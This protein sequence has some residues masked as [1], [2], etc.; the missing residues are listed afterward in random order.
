MREEV[1]YLKNRVA[2]LTQENQLAAI[3]IETISRAVFR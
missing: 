1:A 3:A 2:Q